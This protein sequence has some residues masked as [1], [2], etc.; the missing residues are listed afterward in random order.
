VGGLVGGAV[1]LALVGR[2]RLAG[3][4]GLGLLLF[5]G[6][7]A[8]IPAV[9]AL[10]PVLVLFAAVGIGNTLV[11]VAATTLLQRSV[12]D[13]VLARAFGTLQSLLL[14]A[15]AV[16]SLLAPLLVEGIGDDAA[17]VAL[18]VALPLLAL[19]SVRRLRAIDARGVE[20]TRELELLLGS[21]LFA[22]L[23]PRALE[24]LAGMLEPIEAPAGTILVRAGER[25][26][27]Y[28]LVDEGQVR[29]EPVAAE[30]TTLGPGEGFGEI[31]LLRDVPRTATV[32]ALDDSRLR[33]LG[34]DDFL[35]AV[36]GSAPSLAAA[37]EVISTRLATASLAPDS[38]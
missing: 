25:G 31:A 38:P 30:A 4:F 9:P 34:R 1:A 6:P 32:T 13:D 3:D 36:T 29:V 23:P 7:L 26:D 22:P 21:P 16:G 17:L 28:F 15:M 33:A 37:D 19:A 5:G 27:R 20:P 2:R 24:Q 12:A 10:A 14:G 18:G 8:L 11:D 35:A